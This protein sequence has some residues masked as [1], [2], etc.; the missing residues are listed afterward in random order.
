L[1][2]P[3]RRIREIPLNAARRLAVVAV[4]SRKWALVYVLGLFYG[5]PLLFAAI[6]HFL[7]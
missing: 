4:E 2:F 3:F 7:D 5:I 1:I 6:N